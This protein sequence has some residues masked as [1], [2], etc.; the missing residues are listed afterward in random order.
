MVM[1]IG[2]ALSCINFFCRI[3][4]GVSQWQCRCIGDATHKGSL[5]RIITDDVDACRDATA[6][7]R[8]A[9]LALL[10]D[11]EQVVTMMKSEPD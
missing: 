9:T 10:D 7:R 4:D 5:C 6:H 1:T 8:R 3:D 11:L 2:S